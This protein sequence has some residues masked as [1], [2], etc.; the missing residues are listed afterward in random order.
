VLLIVAAPWAVV[1]QAPAE[2]VMVVEDFSDPGRRTLFSG[3]TSDGA[4]R[5]GYA[6]GEYL[7]GNE[8]PPS[9]QFARLSGRYRDLSLAVDARLPAAQSDGAIVLGCRVQPA[10]AGTRGYFLHVQPATEMAVLR[11]YD[12]GLTDAAVLATTRAEALRPSPQ[13]NRIELICADDNLVAAVNGLP[14]FVVS[15][16]RYAEGELTLG[17]EARTAPT[18]AHFDNLAVTPLPRP[19][20]GPALTVLA[21]AAEQTAA[22]G[23]RVDLEVTLVAGASGAV[24]LTEQAIV[25]TACARPLPVDATGCS[26]VVVDWSRRVLDPPLLLGMDERRTVDVTAE[27]P[28]AL[29]CRRPGASVRIHL[30]WQGTDTRGAGVQASSAGITVRCPSRPYRRASEHG[31]GGPAALAATAELRP[32]GDGHR[33]GVSLTSHW[34]GDRLASPTRGRSRRGEVGNVEDAVWD[35]SGAVPRADGAESDDGAGA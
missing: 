10:A 6:E 17:V 26:A 19:T 3:V 22:P 8:R 12:A 24:T 1:A 9:V 5:F 31:R 15:D 11:R 29:D 35:L 18:N 4:G 28:A 30:L 14:L 2:P 34:A 20:A 25:W 23:D 32:A 33:R 21:G 7:I 16:G 13:G 27:V